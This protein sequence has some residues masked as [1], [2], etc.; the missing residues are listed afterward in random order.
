MAAV[1]EL[2]KTKSLTLSGAFTMPKDVNGLMADNSEDG[3][4]VIG[5]IHIEVPINRNL[6]WS[7]FGRLYELL[8]RNG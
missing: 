2:P 5:G 8:E 7:L 1:E 6:S 3:N 4:Q